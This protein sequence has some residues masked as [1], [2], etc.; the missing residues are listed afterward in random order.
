M[1]N[2]KTVRQLISKISQEILPKED[3]GIRH[4]ISICKSITGSA[5]Y[6]SADYIFAYM[7]LDDEVNLISLIA[8]AF[9]AGKTVFIP[10]VDS[11]K[12]TMTFHEITPETKL[13]RGTFGIL[14]PP[15]NIPPVNLDE[16]LKSP[17]FI[18]KEKY[19]ALI[20]GRAFSD[21]GDRLGRGGG[22]YDR[23]LKSFG[24]KITKFGVCFPFQVLDK[25]PVKKSD[26][27]VDYVFSL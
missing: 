26:F 3:Y 6:K 12:K 16:L 10:R 25:V 11:R 2:K 7:A 5:K 4:S 22:Y 21:N 14:E 9:I 8:D 1:K 23:F 24:D 19:L 15:E 18:S 13:E 20:P 27:K 17:R